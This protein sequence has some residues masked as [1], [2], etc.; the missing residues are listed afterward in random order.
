MKK[1]IIIIITI[2]IAVSFVSCAK[3][4]DNPT[5]MTP[6]ETVQ[7]YFYYWNEKSS[8]GMDSLVYEKQQGGNKDLNKLNSVLLNSCNER[9]EKED[10]YEPWYQNPY[11]YTCVDVSFTVDYKG[12]GGSGLSN[13]TYDY[14]FYLVKESEESDWIIVMWGQ[15][16]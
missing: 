16:A 4:V 3:K 7:R 2:A 1:I 9:T 15:L 6:E 12:K 5:G 11:D 10:W 8:S 13:G 14:K